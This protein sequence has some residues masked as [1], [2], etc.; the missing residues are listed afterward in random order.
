MGGLFGPMLAADPQT[1]SHA[2]EVMR[3]FSEQYA[4]RYRAQGGLGQPGGS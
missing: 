1:D 3:K 4:K 2:L